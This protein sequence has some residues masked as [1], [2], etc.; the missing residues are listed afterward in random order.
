MRKRLCL[1]VICIALLLV[2]ALFTGCAAAKEE[3]IYANLDASGNVE[4]VYAVNIFD[5]PEKTVIVE[6][7]MYTDVKNLVS[8]EEVVK[9]GDDSYTVEFGPGKLYLQGNLAN[10]ALPWKFD[11]TYELNGMPVSPEEA[12]GSA[13]HVTVHIRISENPDGDAFFYK[14]YALNATVLFDTN[15]CSNI[16]ADGATIANNGAKKQLTYTILPNRVS[17]LVIELD[18]VLF[19]MDEISINGVRL[20]M[21]IDTDSVDMSQIDDLKDALRDLT[22]ASDE[23]SVGTTQLYNGVQGLPAAAAQMKT[24]ADTVNSYLQQSGA[25]PEIISVM[26]GLINGLTTLDASTPALVSGARSLMSGAI[27]ISNGLNK[28]R[29]ETLDIDT[30]ITDKINEV[31]DPISIS[32]DTLQSFTSKKNTNVERVQFVMR[33]DAVKVPEPE[34]PP[35]EPEKEMNI[36]ERVLALFGIHL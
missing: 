8:R 14:N 36:F 5:V 12:A 33:T 11:I 6:H 9:T 27:E 3:V 35:A 10:K 2:T 16:A 18:T 4:G 31:L 15:T 34:A 17:D 30:K 23:L 21:D 26:A 1:S 24:A 32:G 29:T 20:S 7:G 19:S 22:N 25:S 13:G 28:L